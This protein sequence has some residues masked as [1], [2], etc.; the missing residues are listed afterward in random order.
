MR[1][2][3]ERAF[4]VMASNI[5]GNDRF[6]LALIGTGEKH[7]PYPDYK[8]QLFVGGHF[9]HFIGTGCEIV[10]VGNLSDIWNKLCYHMFILS[11]HYSI[12]QLIWS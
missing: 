12:C 11:K 2:G 10:A 1:G 8:C 5:T 9:I 4:S 6:H 3:H 7:F